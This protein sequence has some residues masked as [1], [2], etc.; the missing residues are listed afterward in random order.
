MDLQA[1]DL[2]AEFEAQTTGAVNDF[3]SPIDVRGEVLAVHPRS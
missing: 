1:K 2:H 3:T